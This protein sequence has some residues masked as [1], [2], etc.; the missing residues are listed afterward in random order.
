MGKEV[1]NNKPKISELIKDKLHILIIIAIS[2]VYI[3]HGL[4]SFE[5]TEKTPLE[6][7]G[8][9]GW[10]LIIGMVITTMFSNQGLRDGRT[11][12]LFINS[13]KAYAE[14]KLKATPFF[15]KLATWCSYKNTHDLEVKKKELVESAGMN[16]KA[17]IVGYY[18][19]HPEVLSEEQLKVLEDVE[20]CKILRITQRELLSDMPRNKY[21]DKHRF[22]ETVLEYNSKNLVVDFVTRLGMSVVCGL[23]T[24]KPAMEADWAGL[25]WNLLQI[26]MWLGLGIQK[27]TASKY[28]MEYEYRQSHLVQKTELF[29][30]FVVTMQ[31]NPQ[32]IYTYDVNIDE[33]VAKFIKEKQN[34]TVTETQPIDLDN[35]VL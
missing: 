17:Y 11:T 1:S 3:S 21:S 24:L 29:N 25:V 13:L 18:D 15:D 14:A 33:E 34:N 10:S 22:G 2:I 30:E 7:I 5:Q 9:I 32:V 31:N 6:I 8:N 16:Y 12:L 19:E 35:K 28:F 20:T 4:F 23:Y 27:Y 26:F